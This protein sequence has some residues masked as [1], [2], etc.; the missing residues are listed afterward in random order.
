MYEELKKQ[1]MQAAEEIIAAAL[2]CPAL[3]REVL[4]IS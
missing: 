3:T 4:R 1:A 2:E